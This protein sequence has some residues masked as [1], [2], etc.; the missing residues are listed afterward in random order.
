MNAKMVSIMKSH[1][2]EPPRTTS[3]PLAAEDLTEDT[4][5][6]AMTDEDARMVKEQFPDARVYKLRNFVGQKGNIESPLGGTLADYEVCYEHIDLLTKMAAQIIF[7]E[8]E[9]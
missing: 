2:M 1:G 7:R 5:L 9:R 4:L 8:E 3:Q 6:L